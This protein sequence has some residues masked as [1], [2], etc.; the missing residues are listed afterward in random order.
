M[1][2]IT[3][4]GRQVRV[5][6]DGTGSLWFAAHDV[7]ECLGYAHN[8]ANLTRD[9]EEEEKGVKIVHTPGG[10]QEMVCV[11]LAGLSILAG[12]T[13]TPEA[14]AVHQQLLRGFTGMVQEA[15]KLATAV[16]PA[17]QPTQ[18]LA[19]PGGRWPWEPDEAGLRKKV[20][21]LLLDFD[22]HE[23]SKKLL[24]L[25]VSRVAGL[26]QAN[27]DQVFGLVT[28]M[29]QEGQVVL[30]T[31]R[32][33]VLLVGLPVEPPVRPADLTMVIMAVLRDRRLPTKEIIRVVK[34]SR[35][36][37]YAALRLM[38]EEGSIAKG[39]DGL[40]VA[41]EGAPTQRRGEG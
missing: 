38:E 8:A 36:L 7:A 29:A 3:L 16:V 14:R 2:T 6:R 33:G 34:R 4:A 28:R 11:T 22:G 25:S 23:A 20:L 39:P 1:E 41:C 12:R 32:P 37:V 27:S 13:R 26:L 5:V 18:V 35:G 17:P 30:T 40:W 21:D 24:P 10:P 15:E 31:P 9:M 19:A